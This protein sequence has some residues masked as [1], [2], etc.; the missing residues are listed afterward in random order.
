MSGKSPQKSAKRTSTKN[1]K[2][3]SSI[4]RKPPKPA[5]AKRSTAAAAGNKSRAGKV[6]RAATNNRAM[7]DTSTFYVVVEHDEFRISA[8]KPAAK[9]PLH[10]AKTFTEAKEL[11]IDSLIE[12]IDSL[13]GRLWQIKRSK[14]FEEYQDLV[15]PR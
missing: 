4:E 3:R 14:D 10:I 7:K 11:A 8:E 12:L 13:E 5:S 15:K 2:P 9:S 1:S 6:A